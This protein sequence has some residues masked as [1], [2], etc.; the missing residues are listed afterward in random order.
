MPGSQFGAER[1]Y[2]IPCLACYMVV[3]DS[4]KI[5]KKLKG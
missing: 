3:C 1:L 4:Q 2:R 5:S